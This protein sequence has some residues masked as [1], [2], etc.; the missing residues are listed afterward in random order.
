MILVRTSPRQL[1]SI[2]YR[3]Y[4]QRIILLLLEHNKFSIYWKKKMTLHIGTLRYISHQQWN[5]INCEFNLIVTVNSIKKKRKSWIMLSSTKERRMLFL[6]HHGRC[7]YQ[8]LMVGQMWY[9]YLQTFRLTILKSLLTSS[10]L[11]PLQGPLL[12]HLKILPKK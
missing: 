1:A 6:F 9:A 3:L 10:K 2:T 8:I 11:V 4:I 7:W 5:F 12:F